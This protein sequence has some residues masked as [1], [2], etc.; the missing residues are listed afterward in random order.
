M[1]IARALL[2]MPEVLICDEPVSALD[3]SIQAQILN[4]LKEIQK[5]YN[6]T[7]LFISHDLSVT[8]YMSDNIAVIYKGDIIENGISQEVMTNPKQTYTKLLLES[9]LP[10][11]PYERTDNYL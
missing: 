1:N 10:N 9:I 3:I 2:L 11:S 6:L 8:K 7:Y 5:E 4:L